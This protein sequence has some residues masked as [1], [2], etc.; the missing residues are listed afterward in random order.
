MLLYMT[1]NYGIAGNICQGK[2]LPKQ[3]PMYC[4]KYSPDLFS[5]SPGFGEIK[6]CIVSMR[7][8]MSSASYKRENFVMENFEKECVICGY[9]VYKEIWEATIGEE[10]DCRREKNFHWAKQIIRKK[11]SQV[12]FS[13]FHANGEIDEN[14][15]L[16]NISRYTV[17]ASCRPKSAKEAVPE[18]I[19]EHILPCS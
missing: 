6:L 13:P 18:H 2:L 12:K 5:Y 11:F 3:A 9:H 16:V 8:V 15:T 14:S 4:R 7:S 19:P 10:L 1:A 17:L